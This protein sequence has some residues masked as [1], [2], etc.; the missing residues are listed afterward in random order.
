MEQLVEVRD[1]SYVPLPQV[2]SPGNLAVRVK[3]GIATTRRYLFSIQSP[4]GHW[5]GELEGDT[6]LE[7]EYILARHFLGRGDDPRLRKAGEYIRRRSLPDGGW[8]IY[9]G[10]PADISASVKAYFVLKLLGDRADAPHMRDARA[11]ILELGGMNACNSFTK[12]Y[13]AIFGQYPWSQCPSVPPEL[14]LLPRLS[15]LNIYQMSAWSRA[16][17]VPLSIISATRPSCPVPDAAGIGELMAPGRGWR[18]ARRTAWATF[19]YTVDALTKRLENL[20]FGPLREAALARSE[21]WILERLVGSDGLGAIFPPIVNTIIALRA[22]GYPLDHPTIVQQAAELE[23]LTIEETDTLRVQPCFSPVWDTALAI[24]ALLES[25]CR[26]DDPALVR[27]TAW[28]LDRRSHGARDG[29]RGTAARRRDESKGGTPN[30]A[31]GWYFEYANPFYPDCDTT[32]QVLT[33]LSKMELSDGPDAARGQRA[34]YEGLQWHL[35]M[36]NSDGGWGAFDRGCNR[37]ILTR[38]PFADHN[39]M[40]DPSTADLTARGLEAMAEVGFGPEYAPARR[41]IEFLHRE[42]EPDG[43]WYGRWGCNYLYGTYLAAWGLRRIGED[44]GSPALRRAAAWLASCQNPDG[45]WG[46]SLA[47]YD[48]PSHKGRGPSTPSQTAWALMGLMA[49]GKRECE[50]VRRGV[51]YLLD[52]QAPDGS[53]PEE[54]WTGTGFPRVFY[55]K[56]HLYPIYFPLL[57]LG[58]YAGARVRTPLARSHAPRP[59][60]PAAWVAAG[61]AR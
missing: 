57:A 25:G 58:T 3:A 4:D 15:Y 60:A 51:T 45:G 6:I 44:P 50:A 8:S 47:S 18:R 32:S 7:S 38:V 54:E 11:V 23:K 24:N 20:P 61:A 34:L 30:A 22:R 37:E 5:C 46:E 2:P 21:R 26:P 29:A 56:Y 14:I 10:G 41:A 53:W 48:D 49:A 43:S 52:G 12:I 9:P 17:L 55:L 27:A 33:S 19:F 1:P 40:I 39:A 16:I 36:Q 28:V 59:A 13:L 42:Q 35:G 31:A